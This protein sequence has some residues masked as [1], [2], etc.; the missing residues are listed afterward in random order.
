MTNRE[1]YAQYVS[2]KRQ[3]SEAVLRVMHRE[4]PDGPIN[5]DYLRDK[6]IEQTGLTR[7]DI[8]TSISQLVGNYELRRGFDENSLLTVTLVREVE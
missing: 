5:L 8:A 6:A 7:T 1:E 4:S 3:G 2:R